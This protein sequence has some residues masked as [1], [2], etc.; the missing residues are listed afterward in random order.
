MPLPSSFRALLRESPS[1]R[2]A[3]VGLATVNSVD[4]PS[5]QPGRHGHR[6]NRR[7]WL[8]PLLL[9]AGIALVLVGAAFV[10][11]HLLNQERTATAIAQEYFD[12]LA[13]GDASTANA[14]TEDDP[15]S[16]DFPF[17]TDEV[18][19]A[20][21]ERISDVEV[22]AA[23]D[24]L[25]V[26]DQRVVVSFTLA[27]QDYSEEIT[28]SRGD[29]EW[30]VLRTWEM[31]H[32]FASSTVIS[33]YG[34]GTLTIAGVPVNPDSTAGGAELFP[35]VYPVGV[36][37]SR[38]LGLSDED[39]ELVVG[40]EGEFVSL[41]LEPTDALTAEVQRQMDDFLDG[42]VAELVLPW[43][44]EDTGCPFTASGT[45]AD[46]STGSWELTEYP[47]AE[48]QMGGAVYRYRGGDA[49][50]TPDDGGE[51][52]TSLGGTDIARYVEV[53]EDTVT[54]TTEYPGAS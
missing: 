9:T 41:T 11:V 52:S 14:L 8:R 37:E 51:P 36:L 12:A 31:P 50:F 10:T 6:A 20:A 38:W 35:A 3:V 1:D 40:T 4:V 24:P 34:P 42:C 13:A 45:D 44:N 21:T 43:G 15:S 2:L 47:V 18:L 5:A 17:L 23:D 22:V 30:G 7:R 28:V 29:P 26:F 32:P 16:D 49:H 25:D 54:L 53:T 33:V 19:A 27:G 46:T 39:E 48:P